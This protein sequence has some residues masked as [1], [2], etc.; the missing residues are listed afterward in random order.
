[1]S[2]ACENAILAHLASSDDAKISD[3]YEWAGANGFDHNDVVGAVKSLMVDNY[4]QASDLATNFFVL[5]PEAEGIL[6]NG[7]QEMLVLAALLESG[8]DAGL[9]VAELQ[10]KVGSDVCKIGMGNCMKNKW[11]KKDGDR[12]VP[13]KKLDEVSDDVRASLKTLVDA[14]GR[15]DALDDKVNFVHSFVTCNCFY[16]LH[17]LEIHQTCSRA[18]HLG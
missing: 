1:M 15:V 7:S 12:I 13:I 4:L 9:S 8:S 5:T 11:A 16:C 10:A 18:L 17:M 2:E 6:S 14:E 3:T